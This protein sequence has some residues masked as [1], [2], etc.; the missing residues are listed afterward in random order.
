M[1][2]WLE[3]RLSG[4]THR[5]AQRYL[6]RCLLA[7]LHVST[8][9]PHSMRTSQSRFASAASSGARATAI[10]APTRALCLISAMFAFKLAPPVSSLTR[11]KMKG[12]TAAPPTLAAAAS[13]SAV[14]RRTRV[15]IHARHCKRRAGRALRCLLHG[16][17]LSSMLCWDRHADDAAR[18]PHACARCNDCRSLGRRFQAPRRAH[19][20]GPCVEGRELVR[21]Q[22]S[23]LRERHRAIS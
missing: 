21:A 4:P 20:A 10:C 12:V 8:Q 14:L 13:A 2:V 1:G 18:Q 22:R 15:S 7:Q 17:P 16:G 3:P 23:N 9:L 6:R 19:A 11:R 5:Q